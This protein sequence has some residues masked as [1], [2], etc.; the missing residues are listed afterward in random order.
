MLARGHGSSFLGA[1][2]V[3]GIS[4]SGNTPEYR[5]IRL[6]RSVTR[7]GEEVCGRVR[8]DCV[9]GG[10][11]MCLRVFRSQFLPPPRQT[12]V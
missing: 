8:Q 7:E 9:C 11:L 6:Y 10:P 4:V 3:L 2:V 1:G 5:Q 12:K